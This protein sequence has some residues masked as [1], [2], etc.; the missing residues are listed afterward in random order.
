MNEVPGAA[1]V[2]EWKVF[3]STD[4]L[5]HALARTICWECPALLACRGLLKQ[6][7]TSETEGTWAGQLIYRRCR[8]KAA[9]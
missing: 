8:K 2:G 7:R 3:D 4:P 5:D 9:A 1:C 6:V